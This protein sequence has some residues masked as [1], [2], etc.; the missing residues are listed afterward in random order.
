MS[1]QTSF[2]NGTGQYKVSADGIVA[3]DKKVSFDDV[4][5]VAPRVSHDWK[6]IGGMGA[7]G[8]LALAYGHGWWAFGGFMVLTGALLFYLYAADYAFFVGLNSGE[9]VALPISSKRNFEQMDPVIQ[10]H[11]QRVTAA[12]ERE[13]ATA[14]SGSES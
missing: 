10:Y 8:F 2:D 5:Y 14:G 7:I 11:V 4:T 6:M 9:I 13:R 12:R 1:T 3:W